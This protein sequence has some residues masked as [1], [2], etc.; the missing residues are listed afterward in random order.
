MNIIISNSSD[1]PIY[2]QIV[3]QIKNLIIKG[4]LA[5][6]EMLPSI[7]TL[8]KELQISVITTKRAYQ[9]LE[10]EGYIV[11]VQGKGTFVAAQNKEL[12]KE[13]QLKMVEEKLTEAVE[14][15]KAIHLTLEE[16]QEILKVIYEE[17]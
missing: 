5:E 9:E 17:G 14:A 15:G 10:N 1:E 12:L 13:N 11:T 2:Q 16:M 7:R 6:N 8:A 4:E 3:K